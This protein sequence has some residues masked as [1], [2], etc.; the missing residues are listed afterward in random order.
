MLFSTVVQQFTFPPPV[1]RLAFSPQSLAFVVEV[2]LMIAILT[3]CEI[4]SCVVLI[5]IFSMIN[6]VDILRV[7]VRHHHLPLEKCLLSYF[8]CSFPLIG[9]FVC[10]ML[11]C[12]SYL[13]I[14]IE[15]ISLLLVIS[16]HIFFSHSVACVFI[17]LL[18]S[19]A[20]QMLMSLIR[21]H[22]FQLSK[23]FIYSDLD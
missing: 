4:V 17:L 9:L 13:L 16:F 21:F 14:Y 12:M 6:N 19:F 18:I 3:G 7:P 8:A 22:L 1:C 5:C 20:M 11:G 23:A 15:D 2:F 10:W